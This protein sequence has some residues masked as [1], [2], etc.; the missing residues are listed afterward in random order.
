MATLDQLLDAIGLTAKLRDATETIITTMKKNFDDQG[1]T[2]PADRWDEFVK[3]LRAHPIENLLLDIAKEMLQLSPDE[4]DA[5]IAWYKSP[6]GARI[7]EK[8]TL[9]NQ[10]VDR[11]SSTWIE[12]KGKAAMAKVGA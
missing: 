2:F 12:K 3:E 1:A 6:R 11:A 5:V 9:V 10:V 4:M 8:M 7:M